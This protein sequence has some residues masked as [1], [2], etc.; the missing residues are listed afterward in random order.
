MDKPAFPSKPCPKCGK[1]IHARIKKHEECG[2]VMEETARRSK[3]KKTRKVRQLV[4]K[5]AAVGGAIT[6]ADIEA[7]HTFEGTETAPA[8]RELDGVL[9]TNLT[10][11]DIEC[12]PA[13]LPSEVVVNVESLETF[14]DAITVADLKLD[15]GVT[16][17]NEP[18]TNIATVNP[19]RTQE[20]LEELEEAP[21]ELDAE[22]VEVE[23]EEGA[24]G[25]EG[26]EGAEG[27]GGDEKAAEGDKGDDKSDKKE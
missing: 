18:E 8:V 2:W 4:R 23:G 11:L 1:Y 26:E 10:E 25:E 19:P 13:D 27:E 21:E 15:D 17:L 12:L 22:A 14:E 6:M 7:V 20:E 3:G 5:P 9:L 16:I 24:E